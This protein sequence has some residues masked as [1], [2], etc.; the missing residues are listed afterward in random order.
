MEQ[1]LLVGVCWW[2]V[3]DHSSALLVA[4]SGVSGQAGAAAADAAWAAGGWRAGLDQAHPLLIV[5]DE[6]HSITSVVQWSLVLRRQK[7]HAWL[8]TGTS[9]HGRVLA[10]VGRHQRAATTAAAAVRALCG[11]VRAGIMDLSI[12]CLLLRGLTWTPQQQGR[13][14]HM[15]H[16][17]LL[18]LYPA[19]Q[20][21]VCVQLPSPLVSSMNC[22]C[23]WM[24]SVT[25]ALPAWLPEDLQMPISP[26]LS[27]GTGRL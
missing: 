13:P 6:Q 20:Q 27:S 3:R 24:V 18:L 1:L 4:A 12:V 22:P 15:Q 14:Q 8:S 23:L 25:S 11:V 2:D 10:D 9:W 19:M 16:P 5:C 17:M 7:E 21:S 26:C